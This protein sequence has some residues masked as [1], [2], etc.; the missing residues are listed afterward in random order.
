MLD[1]ILSA[2]LQDEENYMGLVKTLKP[3][4]VRAASEVS[5]LL[6][7]AFSYDYNIWDYLGEVY[8]QVASISKSKWFCQYF[9]PMHVCEMMAEIQLGNTRE[10][11]EKA[12]AESTKITVVDPCVG[13][14]AMLLACKRTII[15][16]YGVAP[17][18]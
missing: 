9:T 10:T 17:H 4:A 2:L 3:E 14:G 16:E 7:E 15:Q 11:I 6:I 13:S 18:P 5:G 12:K 1:L 8:M